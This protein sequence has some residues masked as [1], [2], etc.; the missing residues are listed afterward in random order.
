MRVTCYEINVGTDHNYSLFLTSPPT[1][2]PTAFPRGRHALAGAGPVAG[3][4]VVRE[5]RAQAR[6][7]NDVVVPNPVFPLLLRRGGQRGAE[8]YFISQATAVLYPGTDYSDPTGGFAI[9]TSSQITPHAVGAH[10][11]C[12]SL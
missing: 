10:R 12:G 6:A 2:V 4:P 5:F 1:K 11:A 9:R 7:S 3:N 8:Q